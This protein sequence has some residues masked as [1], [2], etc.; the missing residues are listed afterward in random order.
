M[1][2]SLN[3]NHIIGKCIN[4]Y[5]ERHVNLTSNHPQQNIEIYL[6][7]DTVIITSTIHCV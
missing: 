1:T 3:E 7:V 2:I 4:V 6:P 5:F